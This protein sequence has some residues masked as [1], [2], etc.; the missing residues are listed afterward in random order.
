MKT[1][2]DWRR[3][4]S[5]LPEI[6]GGKIGDWGAN[7]LEAENCLIRGIALRNRRNHP[8]DSL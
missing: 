3:N 2:R 1:A 7:S 6:L 4:S 5:Y 8:S